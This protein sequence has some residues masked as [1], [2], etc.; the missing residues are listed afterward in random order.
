MSLAGERASRLALG[1]TALI[2][3]GVSG[4]LT[5]VRLAGAE[6]ACVIA[7][8]CSE[9]QKSAYSEVAGVPVALLGIA[10]YAALVASTLLAGELGRIGGLF[11]ALVGVGFSAWLTYVEIGVIDAICVWCVV[12]AALMVVCL[13][14]AALR[15]RAD[16]E[17]EDVT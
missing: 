14:F 12:S 6:P 5:V 7:S 13:V 15:L 3:L 2:G 1:V 10:A 16:P 8:G 9:V 11:T 4:Y 17:P